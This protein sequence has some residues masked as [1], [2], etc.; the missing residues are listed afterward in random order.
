MFWWGKASIYLNAS[1]YNEDI[2]LY[3]LII[4]FTKIIIEALQ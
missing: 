4:F 1:A 2:M 3:K